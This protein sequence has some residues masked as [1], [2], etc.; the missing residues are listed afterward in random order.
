MA[1]PWPPAGEQVLS[2][3]NAL[4]YRDLSDVCK[5]LK[6]SRATAILFEKL[7]VQCFACLSGG[8]W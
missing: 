2:I 4:L 8:I 6:L 1:L 3:F 5:G 7:L